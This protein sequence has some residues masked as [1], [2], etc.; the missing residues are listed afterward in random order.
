[1]THLLAPL[2]MNLGSSDWMTIEDFINFLSN[3]PSS[4]EF[5]DAVFERLDETRN[6]IAALL[7]NRIP[8]YGLTTGFADLRNHVIPPD[9]ADLL[10]FNVIQSH[11]AGIGDPLPKDV[12]L[13]AMVIRAY[14][15]SKGYSGFTKE[16]LTNLK[17]MINARIIP[18]VPC[19]GSLGASGDLTFLA[20]IGRAMMGE[21]VPVEYLGEVISASKALALAQIAPFKPKA[22]EGL[23][24][25]NGTPFM[26]SMLALAYSREL[27]CLENLLAL[28]GL[29]LNAVGAIDAAFYDSI[30]TVRNQ[31]GQS[32]MAQ[33]LRRFFE[34][35]G[36]ISRIEVQNDYCI[37]C[38]PQIYG[39]RFELI[40]EQQRKIEAELNAV[41]DNPLIFRKEEISADVDSSRLISFQG[42]NWTVLSGGNFHGEN[43]TAI[44]DL[45]AIS[46]AKIA[47]TIERQLTYLMNPFRNKN[48]L[49]PYLILNSHTPGLK[50]GFM[51]TQYTANAL[52]HK[53]CLLAQPAGLINLTSANESEDVVSYG[54]TSCHKL[55]DQIELFRQLLAIYLVSSAQAYSIVRENAS[56]RNPLVEEVFEIIQ[57]KLAFPYIE[58]DSFSAR[59][60]IGKSLLISKAFQN[61]IGSLLFNNR[62]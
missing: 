28:T 57:D 11:D 29:F 40:L 9:Q 48:R 51:I 43:S 26:G 55:L 13:G 23:A 60:E 59:Y 27:E 15:L 50:S 45:I 25:T 39:P 41:T 58:E 31:S 14:S 3:E 18:Q 16:G 7:E 33:I 53:I 12:T 42:A 46:N 20:R 62:S 61:R 36:L 24:L 4:L 56:S 6:F 34:N 22:K 52:T 35:S 32:F 2:P 49:P 19:T 38:L 30:Q 10:S 8:V 44:A 17:Q 54:A 5:S 37:R 1:M 47:L 21:D